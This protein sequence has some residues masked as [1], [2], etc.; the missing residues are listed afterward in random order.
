MNKQKEY[1]ILISANCQSTL[2]VN[3]LNNKL[4]ASLYD[5]DTKEKI[6][7]GDNEKFE[8]VDYNFTNVIEDNI[9]LDLFILNEIEKIIFQIINNNGY[10]KSLFNP[11]LFDKALQNENFKITEYEIGRIYTFAEIYFKIMQKSTHFDDIIEKIVGYD[12]QTD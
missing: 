5:I 4:V 10:D 8:I 1:N 11:K 6:S 12:V 9:S 2:S 7:D 3:S